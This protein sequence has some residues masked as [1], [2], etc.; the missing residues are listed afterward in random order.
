[1]T[2]DVPFFLVHVSSVDNDNKGSNSFYKYLPI[3]INNHTCSALFNSGN[4]WRNAINKDFAF[5]QMKLTEADIRP[6]STKTIGTAKDG[7]SMRVLGE[8]TQ[9]LPLQLGGISTC[10]KTRLVIVEGLSMPF[11]L[12]GPFLKKHKI[13]QIHSEDCIRFQGH[14]KLLKRRKGSYTDVKAALSNVYVVKKTVVK[15][16][17][18]AT[19]ML[20]ATEVEKRSMPAGD[21]VVTGSIGFMDTTNL[22]PWIEAL[23]KVVEDG[24]L[25]AAVMNCTDTAITIQPGTCYCTISLTANGHQ[26]WEEKPWR[27]L[28]YTSCVFLSH[29]T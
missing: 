11:N 18:H 25:I 10:L 23:T 16:M 28:S 5:N 12:A 19:V 29:S 13:D 21:C 1:M 26:A 2:T 15:P 8:V 20:R 9:P 14:D 7:A 27:L 4:I 6:L 3:H 24:R 22:H 17:Q